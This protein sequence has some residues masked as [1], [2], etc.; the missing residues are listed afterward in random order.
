M[1]SDEPPQQAQNE[2]VREPAAEITKPAEFVEPVEPSEENAQSAAA[3]AGDT[4]DPFF[5]DD[6]SEDD[7]GDEDVMLDWGV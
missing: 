1:P 2:A 5:I 3:E 4:N 7:G 6:A